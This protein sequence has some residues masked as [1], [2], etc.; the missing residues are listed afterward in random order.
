MHFEVHSDIIFDAKVPHFTSLHY[1][2]FISFHFV[3]FI[4]GKCST[5]NIFDLETA[6]LTRGKATNLQFK[7]E[8]VYNT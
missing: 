7:I 2:H 4:Q 5:Q 6:L 3:I 1:F 8:T